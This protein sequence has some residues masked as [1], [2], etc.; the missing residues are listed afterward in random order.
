VLEMLVCTLYASLYEKSY[1]DVTGTS[2]AVN[3]FL[4]VFSISLF[5]RL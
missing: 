4:C 2:M 1:G 5:L 3:Q